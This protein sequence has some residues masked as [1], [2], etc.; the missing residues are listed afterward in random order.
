MSDHKRIDVS[1]ETRP[2][3]RCG[4]PITFIRGPSGKVIPAQRVR[5]VFFLGIDLAGTPELST[6]AFSGAR[7]TFVSHFETCPFANEF[8]KSTKGKPAKEG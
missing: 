3:K 7:E 4:L 5:R 2:C 6:T 8:S 1:E